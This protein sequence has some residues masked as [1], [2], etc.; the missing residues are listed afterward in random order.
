MKTLALRANPSHKR[1]M[2]LFSFSITYL[3]LLF[4][5]MGVTAIVRHP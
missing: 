1:A 5:A 4:V 3:A 2:K